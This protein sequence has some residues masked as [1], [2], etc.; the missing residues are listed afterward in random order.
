MLSEVRLVKPVLHVDL[1]K[2]GKLNL[3]ALAR[4]QP[5][6]ARTKPANSPLPRFRIGTVVLEDGTL[7]FSDQRKP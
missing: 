7:N 6:Q 4:P 2:D 1:D 5:A 3:A